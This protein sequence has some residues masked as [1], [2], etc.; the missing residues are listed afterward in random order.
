MT[1]T[2]EEGGAPGAAA[3]PAVDPLVVAHQA[4]DSMLLE[5]PKI[6]TAPKQG[7][8]G[9]VG[10]PVWLWSAPSPTTTGPNVASATA[11]AVTVTATAKVT[12]IVWRPGDGQTVT[13]PGPGTPY[14]A[15]YGKRP[16]PTCGHV[17]TRTSGKQPGA[18]YQLTATSTWSVEWQVQ[19]T[20]LGGEFTETRTSAPAP[21]AIGEAQAVGN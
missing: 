14:S 19:G 8:I 10:L 16:S 7:A 21:L 4:V 20:A 15:A 1:V 13:C 9:L 11:G 12:S 17:Y 2:F 6:Q 5:G 18:K 3:A